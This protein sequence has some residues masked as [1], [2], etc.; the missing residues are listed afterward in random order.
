MN[1]NGYVVVAENLR[2]TY[3]VGRREIPALRGIDFALTE[4]ELT[5]L[6]GPSG[7][8]KTTTLNLVGCLDL[9]TGGSLR[10]AGGEV[11]DGTKGV[12]QGRLD[13]LRRDSIGF[14]FSDFYLLPTLSALE[15]VQVP[16]IWN[17]EKAPDRAAQLLERVGLG[18]RLTHRP[19]ELSGG[20]MQ[21]VALARALINGPAVLLADEPTAN[22]DTGTRDEILTLLRGLTE[23]G[24][25]VLMATHDVELAE[26]ADSVLHIRDGELREV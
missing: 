14:V 20:E 17:D 3:R 2:K 11:F 5:V 18:H 9:P 1:A 15:N 19:D 10:V 23:D 12:S 8:G 22:L 13:A 25:T 16:L 4:G 24:L 21:R 7:A 6:L 26:G